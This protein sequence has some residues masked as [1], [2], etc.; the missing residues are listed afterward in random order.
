MSTF[1][2]LTESDADIRERDLFVCPIVMSSHIL[3][4]FDAVVSRNFAGGLM[5]TL[6][7]GICWSDGL[8]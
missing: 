4:L 5:Q 8:V 1:Q 7:S 2:L 3:G 6:A